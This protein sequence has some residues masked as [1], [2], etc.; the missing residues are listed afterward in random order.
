MMDRSR[1][2]LVGRHSGTLLDQ[3]T[4]TG[5]LTW[6]GFY[7]I[8]SLQNAPTGCQR[9]KSRS[10]ESANLVMSLYMW[11]CKCYYGQLV[12]RLQHNTK[13]SPSWGH[14]LTDLIHTARSP[15]CEIKHININYDHSVSCLILHRRVNFSRQLE[16]SVVHGKKM[17]LELIRKE[18][19]MAEQRARICE[20]GNLTDWTRAKLHLAAIETE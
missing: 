15:W 6:A 3:V 7:A 1:W 5:D 11:V 16:Q 4:R 12:G 14:R 2:R 13:Q 17:Q 10:F 8:P 9:M 18:K 20:W 19:W